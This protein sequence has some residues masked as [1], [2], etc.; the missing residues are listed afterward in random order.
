MTNGALLRVYRDYCN[1]CNT[2]NVPVLLSQQRN[3]SF[4]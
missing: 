1:D 2:V 4:G 3:L